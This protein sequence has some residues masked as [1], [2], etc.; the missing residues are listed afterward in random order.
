MAN[1]YPDLEKAVQAAEKE[2]E[3]GDIGDSNEKYADNHKQGDKKE[4]GFI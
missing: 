1:F 4:K 3:P 2:L